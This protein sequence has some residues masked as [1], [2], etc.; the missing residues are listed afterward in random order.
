MFF[1]ENY[2][3]CICLYKIGVRVRLKFCRI[4][5]EWFINSNFV[6]NKNERWSDLKKEKKKEKK[7]KKKRERERENERWGSNEP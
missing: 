7:E 3:V 2:G 5:R 6:K 1:L 4:F